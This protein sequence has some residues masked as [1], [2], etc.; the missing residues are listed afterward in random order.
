MMLANPQWFSYH[1]EN[2]CGGLAVFY[3]SPHKRTKREPFDPLFCVSP[4]K[5]PRSIVGVGQIQAQRVLAQEQAWTHY[6]TALGASNEG[7]WRRQ[8]TRVLEN[9]RKTYAGEMLAIELTNF[10]VFS[11][12]I[13]PESVGLNDKG[14]S[15]KKE[16]S[17]EETVS[18]LQLLGQVMP[19]VPPPDCV[20]IG[21]LKEQ[22]RKLQSRVAPP[23]PAVLRKIRRVLESYERPSPITQYVKRTRSSTCQLCGVPG[24]VK[25]NGHRY[26]EVHHLFHLSRNP[27]TECL[28]PEFLVV[29]CPTC[30]RRMHYAD[31]GE[32][33]RDPA[34]WRV[35]ID[36]GEH[37]FLVADGA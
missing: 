12:P 36:Q 25:K 21:A 14:W 20:D 29:L 22:L 23:R 24:F 7:E 5:K 9:S 30:H 27:P 11:T 19:Q 8:A 6:G 34:G 3:A 4:G 1:K 32:P 10:Q 35:R 37:L 13:S 16:V 33:V 31:V 18:L 15:D 28:A 17:D 26:C 2:S